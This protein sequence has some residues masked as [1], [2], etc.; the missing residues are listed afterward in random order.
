MSLQSGVRVEYD[1]A[2]RWKAGE[3]NWTLKLLEALLPDFPEQITVGMD[4]AKHQYWCS[5]GGRS[6]LTC[7]LTTFVEALTRRGLA[8]WID[9]LFVKNPARLY[10][11][12]PAA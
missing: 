6:G 2:F 8:A 4:A 7:L 12:G 3:E 11:F 10:A 1:S 5:C 9:R